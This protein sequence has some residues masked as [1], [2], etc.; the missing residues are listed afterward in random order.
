MKLIRKVA[1]GIIL[2]NALFET[3]QFS[4]CNFILTESS[5]L[6]VLLYG[7]AYFSSLI[8]RKQFYNNIKLVEETQQTY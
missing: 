7:F 2:N 1:A 4:V 8:D 3:R 6:Y 5:T